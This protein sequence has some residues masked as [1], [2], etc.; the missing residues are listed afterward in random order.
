MR[1]KTIKRN[2]NYLLK[3][4]DD[5]AQANIEKMVYD[6]KELDVRSKAIQRAMSDMNILS[7][8]NGKSP[9]KYIDYQNALQVISK[10]VEKKYNLLS[11]HNDHNN[12]IQNQISLQSDMAIRWDNSCL[13]FLENYY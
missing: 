5:F 9:T 13:L 8:K 2:T 6:L 10:I 1:I 7:I 11:V 12:C 3:M 4:S